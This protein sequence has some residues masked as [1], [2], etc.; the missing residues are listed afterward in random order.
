MDPVAGAGSRT[1]TRLPRTRGDGPDHPDARAMRRRA[2]PHTRGWTHILVLPQIPEPGFPAHA[3]MDP[4]MARGSVAAPGLPRTR[5]DGPWQGSAPVT[6]P[7]ASP[8]TRGWTPGGRRCAREGAG[9]PAHAG[10]DPSLER[11]AATCWW[12]PRTRG[13]GPL[14]RP[15]RQLVDLASP[16]TRGWTLSPLARLGVVRGFPA[17]A[18]MDPG[19]VA[20]AGRSRRLPR[21]RGDGPRGRARPA[22]APEASPH[23]R[24]W[25]LEA[26]GRASG[27]R[28]FPAH[29]GMDPAGS[30][31]GRGGG[32][33]PRTRGDGPAAATSP[34]VRE[35]ASPHTRGWT[36]Q[37]VGVVLPTGGFP[38]HAGM[39][40]AFTLIGGLAFGL[41]RTR[42]DGPATE[43]GI[44]LITP[45]SPH[46]RGW[47][48]MATAGQDYQRGFPAHA[49]MDRDGWRRPRR[50]TRLPR[51]R[52]DGPSSR[53]T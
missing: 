33:L 14:A 29:A 32:W 34:P 9:F 18:G 8:H 30:R 51:T 20:R 38:A 27:R 37:F 7:Q 16:H 13:D 48:R 31:S 11:S 41:P 49:G 42:G 40:P 4:R 25:T 6:H 43:D 1:G 35:P 22:G 46:T 23:T 12:L 10:M 28:G 39:D 53:P 26:E 24:G 5:G 47:T 50:I 21:T 45:A 19:T 15:V 3:G 52:G 2:S 44:E 36:L 17:H